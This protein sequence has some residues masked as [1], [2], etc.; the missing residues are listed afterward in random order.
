[1][2]VD[3]T[4]VIANMKSNKGS[5]SILHIQADNEHLKD[6]HNNQL[7]R[8]INKINVATINECHQR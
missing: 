2:R 8:N 3:S 7:T 4:S 6:I 5:S 1:M